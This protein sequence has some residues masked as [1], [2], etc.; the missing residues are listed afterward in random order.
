MV[1]QQAQ[2]VDLLNCLQVL[3]TTLVLLLQDIQ[4]FLS[5]TK[6]KFNFLLTV[7][8]NYRKIKVPIENQMIKQ[9]TLRMI[10]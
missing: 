5:E 10:N 6:I 4:Q 3:L 8:L 7:L 9:E 1:Y 2:G